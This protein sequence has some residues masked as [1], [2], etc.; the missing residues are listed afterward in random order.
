MINNKINLLTEN[1]KVLYDS[2]KD[3]AKIYLFLSLND[4]EILTSKKHI[5]CEGND[6]IQELCNR[7]PYY[8]PKE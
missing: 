4:Y 2:C 6:F 3:F 1:E 5:Y 7:C 8:K